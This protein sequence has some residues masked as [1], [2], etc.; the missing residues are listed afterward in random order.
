[1]TGA[2]WGN[3]VAFMLTIGQERSSLIEINGGGDI[4]TVVFTA[5]GR[6]IF[7]GGDK[8][9][10][11]RV[12]DGKRVATM[13]ARDVYCLAVSMY[14]RW[15]AA[16]T[17][18]GYTIVWDAKTLEK[19]FTHR[20]DLADILGVD[21][22]PD[23]TRLVTVSKNRIATVWDVV[24]RKKVLTPLH[25][26]W[27]IAAKY[28]PQGDRIATATAYSVRVWDS[29]DGR[30]LVDILVTLT[31]WYNTG[32]LWSNNHLF[33][34]SGSTIKQFEAS[35][36]SKVSKWLVPDANSS[37]CIALPH[38]G[39]FIA[40]STKDTVAFWDT[41]THTR[42][43]LIQHSQS[44]RSIALSPDERFLGIGGID[45]KIAIGSLSHITVGIVFLVI[46]AHLNNSLRGVPL[47]F[48]SKQDSIPVDPSTFH[49]P[50]T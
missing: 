38:V 30:L 44:I 20:E 24:A 41:S 29:N 42:V 28:S 16:G 18:E 27:V 40:Y 22:S 17:Y 7:G 3:G 47:V 9:G 13:A 23:S 12:K 32:L 21:F 19:V 36:G 50:G 5:N 39:E 45:G 4:W 34:V 8:L 48:L 14:G 31:P 49:I 43:G 2:H 1:M 26:D 10:V 46:I 11:W 35:T 25:E 15:I 6:Y 37:S 33:V